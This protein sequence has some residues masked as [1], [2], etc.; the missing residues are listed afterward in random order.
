MPKAPESFTD[1]RR[2]LGSDSRNT[3]HR[4]SSKELKPAS[5]QKIPRHPTALAIRPPS[6]GALAG[7]K[8][9]MAPTNAMTLAR[10]RP[11]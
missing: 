10:A 3:G 5:A 11:L 4:R 1:L 9:L 7:A 6:I 2:D 8:P